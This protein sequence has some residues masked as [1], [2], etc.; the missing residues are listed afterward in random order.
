MFDPWVGK[1]PWRRKWQ[2]T[3]GLVPGKSHGQRSLVGY[4]PWGRKESDTTERLHFSQLAAAAKLLQSCPT[5]RPHALQSPML[6]YPWNSPGKNSGMGSHSLGQGSFSTQGSNLGLRHC[7]QILHHLSHQGSPYVYLQKYKSR[8]DLFFF[9]LQI[10]S[11]LNSRICGDKQ[12][13]ILKGKPSGF[14]DGLDV[15]RKGKREVKVNS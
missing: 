9:I 1:I 13:S 12:S 5:L 7:R 15:A 2:S 8:Q 10:R 3:L 6:R 4:S 14:V 11:G